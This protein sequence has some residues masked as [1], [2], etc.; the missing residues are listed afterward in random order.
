VYANASDP[1]GSNPTAGMASVAANLNNLTTGSTSVALTTT[2]GPWTVEGTSYAYRSALQTA[3]NPLT[4]G[5][6]TYAVTATD[7]ATPAANSATS[8]G[9]AVN[10]DNTAPTASDVQAANTSGS[11][12]GRPEIGDTITFTYSEPIDPQSILAGWNGTST[13]VVVN[14][15]NNAS[16]TANDLIQ[17][18]NSA[19]SAA[20]PLTSTTAGT[21][22][23]LKA[24]GYAGANRTFGLTGTASTMV[25]SGSP[26]GSI[27]TVT[28][29]TASGGTLTVSTTQS[30]VW[31][32]ST[33]AYDR[34][35]NANTA[36]SKTETG[37]ADK[38]F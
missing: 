36:A 24:T 10:V 20:L 19:N 29:G 23:D 11:I 28:L 37:A 2:G 33:S 32:P 26:T 17:V 12:A 5:A 13:N 35:G 38:D 3:S 9:L 22:L 25:M 31:T 14:L 27:I 18:W 7:A 1:A 4:A 34:A 16:P 30:M 21:G 15:F 8:S 6:T